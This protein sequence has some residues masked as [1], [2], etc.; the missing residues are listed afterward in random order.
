LE[1]AVELSTHVA[2]PPKSLSSN[3]AKMEGLVTLIHR[4]SDSVLSVNSDS[5]SNC[6][7]ASKMLGEAFPHPEPCS[8]ALGLDPCHISVDASDLPGLESIPVNRT[9]LQIAIQNKN[10]SLVRLLLREG[11]DPARHDHDGLTSLHLAVESGQEDVVRAVLKSDVD[12]N[13]PDYS[14]R[15]ALFKAIEAGDHALVRLL[16]DSASD[17]NIKDMWGK[18]ALHLAVEA[19][20]EVLSLLLLEYGAHIDP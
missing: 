2:T 20:S 1:T 9:P 15:T 8:V 6:V 17:P 10:A 5:N 3:D 16:L 14:G 4:R 18:T 12:P 7:V 19:N 13:K 11:A